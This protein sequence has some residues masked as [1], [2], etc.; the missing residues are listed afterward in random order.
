[1]SKFF[2]SDIVK[3]ILNELADMQE[4]LVS[5]IFFIPYMNVEQR[6]EHLELMK[7]FLDKQKLLFFRM[8]LS[9]DPEAQETKKEIIKS[10]KMFGMMENDNIESF[11]N[12]LDR[13]IEGLAKML[14]G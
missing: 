5:Q 3:E 2:K 7:N 1:V 13:T 6:K 8:S 4:E 11:F 9:D 12:N 10:A 14:E